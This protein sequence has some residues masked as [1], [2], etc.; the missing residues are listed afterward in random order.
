MPFR[1]Q[2]PVVCART[3]RHRA[4]YAAESAACEIP[5]LSI[6]LVTDERARPSRVGLEENVHLVP[7]WL[8]EL[9]SGKSEGSD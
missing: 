3:A 6:F 9:E 4:R 7:E 8:Q 5:H 2:M 1:R